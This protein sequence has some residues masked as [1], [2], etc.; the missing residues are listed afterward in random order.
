M[1]KSSAKKKL[2]HK[3]RQKG[4]EIIMHP[5]DKRGSWNGVNHVTRSIPNKKKTFLEDVAKGDY[6]Y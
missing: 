2:D 4:V 6:D 5:K 1:A 3:V